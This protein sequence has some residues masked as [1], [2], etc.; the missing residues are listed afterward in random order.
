MRRGD[1]HRTRYLD[2]RTGSGSTDARP[3]QPTKQSRPNPTYHSRSIPNTQ[4]R[5]GGAD[6]AVL[7]RW[8]APP[9][10]GGGRRAFQG[11]ARGHGSA[12]T[13]EGRGGTTTNSIGHARSSA[14]PASFCTRLGRPAVAQ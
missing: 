5:G 8:R 10:R 9:P 4:G 7:V 11:Q 14:A 3:W 2:Y 1:L 6:G 12:K 13:A